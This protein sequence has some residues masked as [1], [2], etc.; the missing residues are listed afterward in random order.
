ME[1]VSHNFKKTIFFSSLDLH[2]DLHCIQ[3]ASTAAGTVSQNCKTM[4]GKL[5]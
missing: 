1:V 5:S 4:T 3:E 2:D